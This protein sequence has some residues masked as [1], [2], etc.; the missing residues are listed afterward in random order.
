M[1]NHASKKRHHESCSI[2]YIYHAYWDMDDIRY[3]NCPYKLSLHMHK[4]L[5]VTFDSREKCTRLW[6]RDWTVKS[7]RSAIL[8]SIFIG[9][10]WQN[11]CIICNGMYTETEMSY[12][13]KV[14]NCIAAPEVSIQQVKK[15]AWNDISIS[16]IYLSWHLVLNLDILMSKK[17]YISVAHSISSHLSINCWLMNNITP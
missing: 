15:I 17:M 16:V 12:W 7:E 1:L 2:L 4:C 9:V 5:S 10:H 11:R 3:I 6:P 14:R 13:R 8:S